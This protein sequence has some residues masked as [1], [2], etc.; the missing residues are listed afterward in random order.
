MAAGCRSIADRDGSTQQ[1]ARR[2]G[3][4]WIRATS[5]A[6]ILLLLIVS[7]VGVSHGR[8]NT[9]LVRG[10]IRDA[11]NGE[12]LPYVNVLLKGTKLGAVTGMNGYYVIHNVSEGEYHV[13]VSIVGYKKVESEITVKAGVTTTF[14]A[15]LELDI[16][17]MEAIISSGERAKFEQDVTVSNRSLST[18]E[19]RMMPSLAEADLFRSLQMLPGVMAQND[20]FSQLYVR[21][22]SP[23]QNLVLLDGVTVYNP[24]HLGGIFSTFNVDAVKEAELLLGGFPA[25]YGGRLASVLNVI[26]KDGN[27]KGMEGAAEVSLLSSKLSLE[28]PSPKGSWMLSGRRTYF[29]KIV[30]MF[31]KEFPYYFYDFHGKINYSLGPNNRLILSGLYGKDVFDYGEDGTGEGEEQEDIYWAWGNKTLGLTWHSVIGTRLLS[32]VLLS[33]TSFFTDVDVDNDEHVI[34]ANTIRDVTLQGDWTYYASEKHELQFGA[35]VRTYTFSYVATVDM[36]VGLDN[37]TKPSEF[38][39]YV[40]DK[41]TLSPLLSIQPGVRLSHFSHGRHWRTTPRCGFRYRLNEDLAL[42][43]SCGLYYQYLKTFNDE[44][45]YIPMEMWFADEDKKPG[46]AVHYILGLEQ[47]FS[48]SLSLTFEGYYKDLRDILAVNREFT[49]DDDFFFVGRGEAYGLEV[50]AKKTAG[51][52]MGWLG[53]SYAHTKKEMNDQTYYTKY[54]RRHSLN[55]VFNYHVNDRWGVNIRWTMGGGLPYSRVIGRYRHGEYNFWSGEWEMYEDDWK[56]IEGTKNGFRYPTY[57]RIDVS[58]ARTYKFKN[59]DL[60]MYIQVINVIN[61]KNIL[62]YYFD[63]DVSPPKKKEVTM[64]PFVPTVGFRATF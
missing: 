19:L 37:A 44:D 41:W 39:V 21:G 42:N 8:E 25:Q 9:G 7:V 5:R 30:P 58:L 4:S 38:D 50:L 17:Q 31:N 20:F 40:Q 49:D 48:P 13:I 3:L 24:Y 60:Q 12:T 46:R 1:L 16:I 43:G 22:S 14:D 59:W 6:N 35:L 45:L 29:D 63:H 57:N 54:D 51:R 11:A 32:H 64:F 52:A 36:N 47:W 28:G 27:S 18:R 10:V 2:H 55:A 34:I 61:K 53:Y 56:N 26:N 33:W 23:D 15:S 62:W